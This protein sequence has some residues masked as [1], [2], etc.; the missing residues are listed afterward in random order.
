MFKRL[1]DSK[2][3]IFGLP[4]ASKLLA[5]LC[6]FFIVL[7]LTSKMPASEYAQWVEFFSWFAIV[8]L[9]EGVLIQSSR[10]PIADNIKLSEGRFK[11][12]AANLVC[13]WFIFAACSVIAILLSNVASSGDILIVLMVAALHLMLSP[14]KAA[15]FFFHRSQVIHLQAAVTSALTVL[16]I[17]GLDYFSFQIELQTVISCYLVAVVISNI[18]VVRQYRSSLTKISNIITLFRLIEFP[19]LKR[20][21]FLHIMVFFGATVDR[22]ILN[23]FSSPADV[24]MFDTLYRVLSPGLILV[25]VANSI[26]WG[27]Y[28]DAWV[29][30]VDTVVHKAL[31]PMGCL[32]IYALL[33]IAFF[34]ISTLM[35]KFLTSGNVQNVGTV[36]YALVASLLLL[37][38]LGSIFSVLE[39][40]RS[41]LFHQLW[42]GGVIVV[43]KMSSIAFLISQDAL[44]LH[45]VLLVSAATT[46]L[47]PAYFLLARYRS[48]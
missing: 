19:L 8:Y 11:L 23:R 27:F 45:S 34:P 5:L 22:V 12:L 36:V 4:M 2:A 32:I 25:S 38:T 47:W 41:Q 16:L 29:S 43:V 7:Y 21:S 44:D 26:V 37:Q 46:A 40:A 17:L 42:L 20:Y 10:N 13:L 28:R 30:G 24:I 6:Q 48:A 14:L 9:L 3:S 35:L 15:S 1:I 18:L 33:L 39:N 31:Y